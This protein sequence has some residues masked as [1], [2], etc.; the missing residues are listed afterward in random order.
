MNLIDIFLRVVKNINE[1]TRRMEK[2]LMKFISN[3]CFA[4]HLEK[5]NRI[6]Y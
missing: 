6:R 2:W 5:E 1:L 4:I 3:K